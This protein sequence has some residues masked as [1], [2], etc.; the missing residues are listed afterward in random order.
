MVYRPDV[1]LPVAWG[2]RWDKG[3]APKREKEDLGSGFPRK[4]GTTGIAGQGLRGRES[5]LGIRRGQTP[6]YRHMPPSVPGSPSPA[7]QAT[8]T[9]GRPRATATIAR[10][11]AYLRRAARGHVS[12]LAH[13]PSRT[14]SGCRGGQQV[15]ST[16]V[17]AS[18]RSRPTAYPMWGSRVCVPWLSGS[19]T[20]TGLGF[21]MLNAGNTSFRSG[22]ARVH[23]QIGQALSM[24]RATS[25]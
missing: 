3:F 24:R 2:R 25:S 19:R 11:M 17:P 8:T 20:R 15:P 7:E 21:T 16:P 14:H 18:I 1:S 23:R 12:L 22:P 4:T 13:F 6:R 5:E 10:H 9:D